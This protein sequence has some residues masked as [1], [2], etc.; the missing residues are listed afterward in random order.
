ML[1]GN[2]SSMPACSHAVQPGAM[3]MRQNSHSCCKP[4][5]MASCADA[6]AVSLQQPQVLQGDKGPLP[7]FTKSQHQHT[8]AVQ[9]VRDARR[10]QP[11][12]TCHEQP[13]T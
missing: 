6:Q 13:S 9:H 12:T 3:R 5:Q 4:Q 1:P 2:P 7:L 11:G 8:D 10:Q